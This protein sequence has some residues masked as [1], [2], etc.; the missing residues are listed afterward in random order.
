MAIKYLLWLTLLWSCNSPQED[1]VSA[2]NAIKIRRA[3]RDSI[4]LDSYHKRHFNDTVVRDDGAVFIAGK[5]SLS[6]EMLK[7]CGDSIQIHNP[8]TFKKIVRKDST[9]LFLFHRF[10]SLYNNLNMDQ[11][12]FF[13]TDFGDTAVV[14]AYSIFDKKL[15]VGFAYYSEF[16]RPNDLM[17]RFISWDLY[18]INSKSWH[19]FFNLGGLDREPCRYI[20]MNSSGSVSFFETGMGDIFYHFDREHYRQYEMNKHSILNGKSGQDTSFICSCLNK[21][22]TKNRYKITSSTITDLFD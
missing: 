2:E 21:L 16:I 11:F 17:A 22:L 14:G 8:L 1:E 3:K 19:T 13:Y 10:D 4:V 12:P 6:W 18:I 15:L 7:C 9:T 5:F 20:T